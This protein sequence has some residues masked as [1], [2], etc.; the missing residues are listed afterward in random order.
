MQNENQN[1]CYMTRSECEERHKEM[2]SKYDKLHDNLSEI[3]YQMK[4]IVTIGK[5]IIGILG[6]IASAVLVEIVTKTF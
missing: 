1:E 4:T 6:T 3:S 2:E 5:Y